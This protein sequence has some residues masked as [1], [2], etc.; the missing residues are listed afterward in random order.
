MVIQYEK[1]VVEGEVEALRSGR[2]D[3]VSGVADQQQPSV[4]QR[5]LDEAAEG[6]DAAG[7]DRSL[8]QGEAVLSGHPGLELVP[9]AVVRPCVGVFGRVALEYIR[10]IDSVR[11][12]MRA[13]P[14]ADRV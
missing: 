13:K 9:D 2:R 8:R 14:R 1:C 7:G 10:C 4:S 12:L 11:W 6:K 5:G 3:R